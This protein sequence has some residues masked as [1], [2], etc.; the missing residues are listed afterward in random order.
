MSPT[1]DAITALAAS[2]A[3]KT[4]RGAFHV[5]NVDVNIT[6]VDVSG[7]ISCL[8]QEDD[9]RTGIEVRH[10]MSDLVKVRAA[11]HDKQ[12]A[13]RHKFCKVIER[14]DEE[15]HASYLFRPIK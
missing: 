12:L 15:L 10:E 9:V 8:A 3:S 2:I 6:G 13:I 14:S 7:R 4:D 1:F 11:S 5:A